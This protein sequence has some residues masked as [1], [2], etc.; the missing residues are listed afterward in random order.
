VAVRHPARGFI[1]VV[2]AASSGELVATEIQSDLARLEQLLRWFTVKVASLPSWDG[3]SRL[4]EHEAPS[5][6]LIVRATRG[7][8]AMGHEFSRQLTAA[9]P[10][11]PADALAA[12]SGSG[13][14]PGPAIVWADTP[15]GGVRFLDR[16]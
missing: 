7:T 11:H 2:L 5:R 16:R 6:L 10:A 1:D 9:Y 14:W 13:G 3:W 4:G 15:S 12:L 8:R